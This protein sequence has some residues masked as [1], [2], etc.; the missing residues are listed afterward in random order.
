VGNDLPNERSN[1]TEYAVTVEYT[2]D[3]IVEA[4]SPEAATDHVEKIIPRSM[5]DTDW[6]FCQITAVKEEE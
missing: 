2:G 3:F 5:P 4:D 6:Y 1:M